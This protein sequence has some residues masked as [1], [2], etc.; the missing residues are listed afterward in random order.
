[1][2]QAALD[3]SNA[4]RLMTVH[5]AKG[6]EFPIVFVPEAHL[7][8]RA[9]NDSVH[10]RS[11]DGISLTLAR[12]VGAAGSRPCPGFYTY[13]L[14]RD[15]A[16]EAAE[17]K[18][19]SYV[20]ATRAADALYV[21]GNETSSGDG[22]LAAA[23]EVVGTASRDGVEVRQPLIVGGGGGARRPAPRSWNEGVSLFHLGAS[24]RFLT[25]ARVRG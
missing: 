7:A 24:G 21:S 4:V 19:L 11:A 6:L 5:G 10:W 18:R 2:E 3:A 17:R 25:C 8:S 12:K 22:W 9:D 15:A 1:M 14:D 16:A 20:A 23:L 13:L